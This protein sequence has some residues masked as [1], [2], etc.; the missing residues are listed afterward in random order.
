MPSDRPAAYVEGAAIVSGLPAHVIDRILALHLSAVLGSLPFSQAQR[1]EIQAAKNAIHRAADRYIGLPSVA[2]P[3]NTATKIEEVA[4]SW[5][6]DEITTA[7]AGELLGLT[8]RRMRQLAACGMGRKA[9]HAWLLDR[10]M[11]LAY[12]RNR[13]TA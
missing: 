3:G 5:S 12:S 4:A 11:V 6:P 8:E 7:E 2:A 1:Q 10:S 13:R 9:G